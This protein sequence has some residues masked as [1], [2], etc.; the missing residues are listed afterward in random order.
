MCELFDFFE[1]LAF[2]PWL[3]VESVARGIPVI[4][5]GISDLVS[6]LASIPMLVVD[7]FGI[8]FFG[9]SNWFVL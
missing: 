8:R 6:V 9:C 1:T 5:Q 7:L 3:S 2:G 4:G